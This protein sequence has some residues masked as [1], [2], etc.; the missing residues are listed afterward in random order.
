MNRKRYFFILAVI[1]A[2]CVAAISKLSY[3]QIVNGEENHEKS[4]SR[5]QRT[6]TSYAPRGEIYDRYGRILVGNRIGYRVEYQRVKGMNDTE[7]NSTINS[8]NEIFIK[9]GDTPSVDE[10][11]ITAAEPYVFTFTDESGAA[12][13]KFK[14][15]MA[16]PKDYTA[17][18]V[19]EYY[20]E[21]FNV[22]AKYTKE[23][24]RTIVG[25]RY[26]MLIRGFG[27]NLSFT[28]AEDVSQD[29]VVSI[30]ENYDIYRGVNVISTPV[31]EYPHGNLASHI[32]GRI[33]TISYE[34]YQELKDKGYGYNDILG[35]DGIEKYL[36]AQLRGDSG[37]TVVEQDENGHYIS[38]TDTKTV[39]AGNSVYLTIDLD[40]QKAAEKA[41]EETINDI[42]AHHGERGYGADVKG[43]AA[44]A[45][46]IKTGEVLCMASYPSYSLEDFT[47]NYSD[48][49]KDTKNPLLNRSLMG[50]YAPGSTFKMLVALTALEEGVV[51][52]DTVIEDKVIYNIGSSAFKCLKDHDFV[53][54]ETAIRDSCNYYFYSVAHQMGIEPIAQNAYNF[55]FG[56]KTGIEL[57]ESKGTVASPQ[58]K[59]ERNEPWY[60]GHTLQAAIGQDDN[61]FTPIQ[62]ASYV[63]QIA[64]GGERYKPY[65]VKGLYSYDGE[66]E[67]N[68]AKP[69]AVSRL[70][71]D[72][73]NLDAVRYGMRLVATDG[74]GKAYFADY[75]IKVAA[76]TGTA[77]VTGGSDNGL[78][79]AFAPY[80]EPE[81]AVAVVI[82]HS[83]GG[84]YG[85]PV[86]KAIIDA[87]LNA[88]NEIETTIG[89][90]KLY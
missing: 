86:V 27:T 53:N 8:I 79:V 60:I 45:I 74:T 14:K 38:F 80:E 76:K 88:E 48:L 34:E 69:E 84:A 39:E 85:G 10:L 24:V 11:P 40:V 65:L 75:P 29:T 37:K 62:L 61:K 73:E 31:R 35:K 63:A 2:F 50:T 90:D 6:I 89:I 66:E 4:L 12:E 30:K 78:F 23:E 71:L 21:L 55:G 43:G 44:V 25:V 18:K 64:S 57:S 70:K 46:N 51:G 32:L 15:E 26:S 56:Q 16:I 28:L 87:Y 5:T 59:E 20:K 82:E 19:I 58:T 36:E 33:G 41:L 49:L 13:E 72:K 52:I 81:I 17:T 7:I 42:Y 9:N 67:L 77:E 47:E 68:L 54:V 83:G 1:V 22:D 3:L